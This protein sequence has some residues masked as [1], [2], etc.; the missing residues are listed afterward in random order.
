VKQTREPSAEETVEDVRNV[1]DG[2]AEAWDASVKD[3]GGDA[4]IGNQEPQGR[5]SS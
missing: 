2:A 1:E 4:A 3:A 5:C